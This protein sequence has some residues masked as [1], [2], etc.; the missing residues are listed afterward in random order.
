MK[1]F[2]STHLTPMLFDV[3]LQF[4]VW[5]IGLMVDIE[6]AYLQIAGLPTEHDNL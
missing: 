1:F 3:L 4:C 5:N 2:I 6:K